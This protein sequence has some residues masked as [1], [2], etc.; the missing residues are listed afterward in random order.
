MTSPLLHNH[1]LQGP[2]IHQPMDID[3]RSWEMLKV[4]WKSYNQKEL[5]AALT[6]DRYSTNR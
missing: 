1:A 4:L 3:N 2:I 6:S 5:L